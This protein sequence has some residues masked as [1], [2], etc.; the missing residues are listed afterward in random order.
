MIPVIAA[1]SIVALVGAGLVRRRIVA[2][3]AVR[4]FGR[5]PAQSAIV[6]GGLLVSSMVVSAALVAGDA[7]EAMFLDNVYRVW[8]P[9]DLVV[10][11]LSGRPFDEARA[12]SIADNP[13]VASL[14]DGRSVRLHLPSSVE[15]AGPG[16]RESIVNLIGIDPA[17]ERSLQGM[18]NLAGAEV[19]DP[20]SSAIVNERMAERLNVKQGDSLSFITIGFKAQPVNLTLPI[21][22][23][24]RDEGTANFQLR[25]NAFVRLDLL[26]RAVGGPGQVNQVIL[27]ARGSIR[28]PTGVKELEAEA[29]RV[30]HDTPPD[31][32][33]E[34]K[35]LV[36]RIAGAKGQSI[37][38]AREQS[39]FFESVLSALGA[40]V[41]LTSIAL[42][43]NLF[44]MLGEERRSE[45]GML[46]AIGLRR[47]GLLLLGLAEG[48]IYSL[49]AA[50]LGA[51]VGAVL[52]GYIGGALVDLY[53][54][55]LTELSVEFTKP[56]FD[57]KPQTML[58]AASIGFLVTVLAVGF[59]SLKT[60]RLSVVSAIRGLPEE[61]RRKERLPIGSILL[62]L[63]GSG[64]VAAGMAPDSPVA[65]PVPSL[66][67]GTLMIAGLGGV[68]SRYA[69]RRLGATL[70]SL[71]AIGWGLWSYVYLPDFDY[72]F[73]NAFVVV[74]AAAVVI[75]VS[76]VVLV[77]ANLNFLEGA[78]V[79]FG[80]RAR[81]VARTATAY[82]VGYRFRTAMSMGMFALVLYMIAAFAIWGG[83]AAG[84][85]DTQSGGFD[86]YAQSTIPIDG[87]T[88]DGSAVVGLFS[89]RYELGYEVAGS[90]EIRYPVPLYGVDER[91]AEASNFRFVQKP[92][93]LTEAEVW[94]RLA[95]SSDQILL[96]SG[97]NPGNARPGDDLMLNTDKGPRKMKV[98]GVVDEFWMS[99]LFVSKQTFAELYPTRASETTWLVKAGSEQRVEELVR[100]IEQRYTGVGL[101]ARS[102]R[103]I[104]EV[105]AASQRTFVGLFQVLLKLGLVIG[106]SGLAISAVR[107]V[108]ERRH[109]VGVMRAIGFRRWMVGASLV[110]ESLLVATLGCAIGLAAGLP[111]TYLLIKEQ[112]PHV[113]FNADWNQILETLA[114]VYA[115]VFLFTLV[116]AI[117]AARLR[118]AEAVRYVE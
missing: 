48:V 54:Q 38:S 61:R 70:A 41:A 6:V 111:G 49:A 25:P 102:V 28:K 10:G 75:V 84:D 90:E 47:G 106:I 87:F 94:R 104:F 12:R 97:T 7:T 62:I 19:S 52:G 55:V 40:I 114:I 11:T 29:L 100:S 71:A 112:L 9:V 117:R 36:Y 99:A 20:G 113:P 83:L 8:G 64:A 108:L 60:S 109:A 32:V 2:R 17:Q 16:T 5:R 91:M 42:I 118:P 73:N 92:S 43:A 22:E 56:S 98:L 82:P 105:E 74:T 67:G 110:L 50:A 26:Q 37:K 18:R 79:L 86:V 80:A 101:D 85:F 103:E 93:H 3:I 89:G 1:G 39:R 115:A 46:R 33:L 24:V 21:A 4:D 23:I 15:A 59:V 34:R 96:D 81:A 107:T 66:V 35:D 30:A 69:S 14:T 63:A 116:P 51:V 65:G 31:R 68:I 95:T 78:S 44:V 58:T 72:D 13:R 88:S 53:S 57:F 45:A 76:G 27:S 77:S